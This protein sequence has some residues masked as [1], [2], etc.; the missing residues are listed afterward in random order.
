MSFHNDMPLTQ[1]DLEDAMRHSSRP[2]HVL[3]KER[4]MT[5]AFHAELMKDPKRLREFLIKG[6]FITKSG[7]LA[8]MYRS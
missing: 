6:G 4:E 3:K 1:E 5:R 7:K 8:K 2:Y